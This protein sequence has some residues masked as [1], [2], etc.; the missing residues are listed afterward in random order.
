[1][2][3]IY[4]GAVYNSVV[5]RMVW[6]AEENERAFKRLRSKRNTLIWFTR[7]KSLESFNRILNIQ[8]KYTL[9]N[10]NP[11]FRLK[12]NS[13]HIHECSLFWV[14]FSTIFI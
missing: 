5:L 8:N 1:M 10:K 7:Y 12:D 3:W 2:F 11:S 6:S 9:S 14:G 13:V 4:F